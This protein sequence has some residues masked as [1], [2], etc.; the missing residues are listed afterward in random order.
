VLGSNLAYLHTIV[1][2]AMQDA[3]ERVAYI[4]PD[5]RALHASINGQ[6]GAYGHVLAEIERLGEQAAAK[7]EK[8]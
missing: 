4:P 1:N 3:A 2:K 5:N 8:A 6:V 7:G